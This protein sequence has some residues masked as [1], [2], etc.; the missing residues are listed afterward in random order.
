M[1]VLVDL[2]V[3]LD[4]FLNR[5]AWVADSAAVLQANHDGR[6]TIH[7]SAVTLPTIFYIV[8]RQAGI[9]QALAVVDECLASFRIV[10]VSGTTLSLARTW[11]GNDYEDNVQI[12]CAVEATVDAIITRD[13]HGFT[14]APTPVLTPADLVARLAGGTP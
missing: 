3:L 8:R 9:P 14:G 11:A 12:A 1:N 4:V 6:I 10:A 5:A 2:N 7:V 13:P